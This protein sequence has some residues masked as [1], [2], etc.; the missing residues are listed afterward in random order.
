[1]T[2]SRWSA[3]KE[4][5]TPS[6]VMNTLCQSAS[7]WRKTTTP[8]TAAPR[9]TMASPPPTGVRQSRPGGGGGGLLGE[10]A[11]TGFGLGGGGGE[12]GFGLGGGGGGEGV[13]LGRVEVGVWRWVG[14]VALREERGE[15]F[16]DE[17]LLGGQGDGADETLEGGDG[18]V[19][20]CLADAVVVLGAGEDR[21]VGFGGGDEAGAEEDG[22][23]GVGGDGE[24]GGAVGAGVAGEAGEA[25]VVGALVGGE[26]GEGVADDGGV[27][28]GALAFE[29]LGGGDGLDLGDHGAVRAGVGAVDHHG[30]KGDGLTQVGL[31]SGSR[32]REERREE[33]ERRAGHGQVNS[34]RGVERLPVLRGSCWYL[35]QGEVVSMPGLST[36]IA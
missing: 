9:P 32:E 24:V 16:D 26:L 22:A 27:L 18:P 20:G 36:M 28:E 6:R 17:G 35:G 29:E 25:L 34:E 7:A 11:A 2:W 23:A 3:G 1:M 10:G 12:R 8:A 33:T 14:A 5:K 30:V 19:L 15:R 4:G 31:R 21:A 13:G